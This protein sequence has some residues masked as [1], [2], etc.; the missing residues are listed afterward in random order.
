MTHSWE[1]GVLPSPNPKIASLLP[2]Y[3][4]FNPPNHTKHKL[5]IHVTK[6]HNSDKKLADQLKKNSEG[7]R[8]RGLVTH[9]RPVPFIH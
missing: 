6:Q 5:K 7:H 9:W 3:P 4:S 1:T 8:V 2:N